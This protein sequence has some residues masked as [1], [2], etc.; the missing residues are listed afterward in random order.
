[1]ESPTRTRGNHAEHLVEQHLQ[2]QQF[3]T[4]ARNYSVLRC[5]IDIIARKDDLLI[6]VEVKSR[7]NSMPDYDY[8][9]IVNHTKQQR[10]IA[11]AYSYLA[12]ARH[13]EELSYRFDV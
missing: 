6:F 8:G 11:A 5:E 12:Q 4:L 7:T 1:M 3:V 9:E 10:I 2:Q 13:Q